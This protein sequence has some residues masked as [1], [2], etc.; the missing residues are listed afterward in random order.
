MKVAEA[1]KFFLLF[2]AQSLF[3]FYFWFHVHRNLMG[4][5]VDFACRSVISPD[6]YVGTNEIG[7]PVVFAKALS[8]PTPVNMRNVQEM[9]KLV[10]NG[11]HKY[12]GANFVQHPNGQR[13]D[14][15]RMSPSKREA[16]AATLLSKEGGQV[17][18]G[19]QIRDGD[20]LLMN[21]QVRT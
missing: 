6:P 15:E 2:E 9:R 1:S 18:V 12:P 17:I 8:Y 13:F 19:R 11:A 14:L 10:S 3:I 20:M 4:K 7:L 21:R 16:L 5:R